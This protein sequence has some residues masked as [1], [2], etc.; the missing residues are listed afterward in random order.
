VFGEAKFDGWFGDGFRLQFRNRIGA[1]WIKLYIAPAQMAAYRDKGR[2]HE[3]VTR[4]SIERAD[5][6]VYFIG[7]I[8]I[9]DKGD[10]LQARVRSLDYLHLILAE[11]MQPIGDNIDIGHSGVTQ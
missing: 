1:R 8:E 5:A 10:T 11:K 4:M 7:K 6:I 9:A 3:A 2:I